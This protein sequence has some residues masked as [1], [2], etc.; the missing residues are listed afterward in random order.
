MQKWCKHAN[1]IPGVG[2]VLVF[3]D[4][5]G[6]LCIRIEDGKTL[7]LSGKEADFM[8]FC[9]FHAKIQRIPWD[10]YREIYD[11]AEDEQYDTEGN[12]ISHGDLVYDSDGVRELKDDKRT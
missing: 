11:I 9:F 3:F 7:I 10:T 8:R 4:Q 5:H 12:K 1:D 6:Q 2:R